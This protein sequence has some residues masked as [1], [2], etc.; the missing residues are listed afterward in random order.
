MSYFFILL[1]A[2]LITSV[3]SYSNIEMNKNNGDLY[4]TK[5]HSIVKFANGEYARIAG[6]ETPGYNDGPCDVALFENPTAM[7]PY[8]DVNY[9]EHIGF[10]ILETSHVRF[11][12]IKNCHVT[13]VYNQTFQVGTIAQKTNYLYILSSKLTSNYINYDSKFKQISSV[14]SCCVFDSSLY[15]GSILYYSMGNKVQFEQNSI[16]NLLFTFPTGYKLTLR[17]F[18]KDIFAL[19]KNGSLRSLYIMNETKFSLI[20]DCPIANDTNDFYIS[21]NLYTTSFENNITVSNCS[22]Y[23]YNLTNMITRSKTMDLTESKTTSRTFTRSDNLSETISISD[24][25]T[26]TDKISRTVSNSENTTE[27]IS[28]SVN[29][30]ST[31]S[32]SENTSRTISIILTETDNVSES[33]NNSAEISNSLK[34]ASISSDKTKTLSNPETQSEMF[35]RTKTIKHRVKTQTITILKESDNS[36]Q[37]SLSK[38]DTNAIAGFGTTSVAIA[39]TMSFAAATSGT[40]ITA[41]LKII[42]DGCNDTGDPAFYEN[43]F[44]LENAFI[45]DF[46]INFFVPLII[47]LVYGV[48]VMSHRLIIGGKPKLIREV[49]IESFAVEIFFMMW[50]IYMPSIAN[51]TVFDKQFYII[52]FWLLYLFGP[53]FGLC[54][55]Y[56][57]TE[58]RLIEN[59]SNKGGFL[60]HEK[61]EWETNIKSPFVKIFEGYKNF[62][63]FVFDMVV[64]YGFSFSTIINCQIVPFYIFG[65]NLIYFLVI[66]FT[67]FIQP[68]CVI[69][70]SILVSLGQ[71]IAIAMNYEGIDIGYITTILYISIFSGSIVLML[72]FFYGIY[73]LF[74]EK[75]KH[76]KEIEEPILEVPEKLKDDYFEL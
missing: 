66:V 45:G 16:N 4:L 11:L 33:K 7:I 23:K 58:I 15:N 70:G 55:Y 31:I 28:V 54:I 71:I 35:S 5:N 29:I 76:P 68:N 3:D 72:P 12:S 65:L 44:N 42:G 9:K 57:T 69:I 60:F 47:L 36:I 27:T 52:I 13:T 32:E 63:G 67:G 21:S 64:A 50:C 46:L 17:R 25:F 19:A 34:T 37:S 8:M 20:E 41:T 48:I 18:G 2:L 53:F 22:F 49:I 43:P 59:K 56:F 6:N 14:S 10:Y 30:S 1:S 39:S 62:W 75:L 61:I 24:N 74:E 38:A 73:E 51:E 40:R 26:E